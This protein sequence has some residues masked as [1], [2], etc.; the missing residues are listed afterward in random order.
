MEIQPENSTRQQTVS[1][2]RDGEIIIGNT[3]FTSSLI[4]SPEMPP[5][6]WH[7]TSFKHLRADDL[8]ALKKYHP[9]IILLGTG[10]LTRHIPSKWVFS[11]LE[12]SILIECMNNRMACGTYNMMLAEERN[13]LLAII[14]E[15][16][17]HR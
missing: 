15:E 16:V 8:V 2:Y 1:A 3:A 5:R 6:S 17:N 4:L 9:D 7:I 11:L 14:M 12:N 13:P 10:S